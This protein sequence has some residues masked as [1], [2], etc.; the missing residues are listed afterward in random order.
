M[1]TLNRRTLEQKESIL[2]GQDPSRLAS[3][4]N[5]VRVLD[6]LVKYQEGEE[7]YRR[8]LASS[9][10]VL[11]KKHPFTLTSMTNL[12]YT[13]KS[14]NCIEEAIPLMKRCF[15]LRGVSIFRYF[16]SQKLPR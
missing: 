10:S 9:E 6:S 5:L 7:I 16:E 15:K 2:G 12:A 1:A 14:R 8:T 3:M 13:L 11:G 4:N